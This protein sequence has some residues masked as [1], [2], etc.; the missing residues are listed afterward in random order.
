MQAK[1]RE[2]I[3][4]NSQCKALNTYQL[5]PVGT[6]FEGNRSIIQANGKRL[7][8]GAKFFHCHKCGTRIDIA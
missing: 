5:R 2:I 6:N 8:A 7:E 1:T 3:C 4:P